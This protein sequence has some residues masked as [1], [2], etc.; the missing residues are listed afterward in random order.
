MIPS[1]YHQ[2]AP[3]H[4]ASADH[5]PRPFVI[6][7]H[8][9]AVHNNNYRTALWTGKHLQLTVMSIPPGEDIGLEVHP[10]VDQFLRIEAGRGLVQMGSYRDHLTFYQ[11]VF[12][13]S[14]IFIP[15]GTWH[16]VTNTGPM[17][18][19]LYSIY[20]PPNHR[21]SVVHETKQ[22]AEQEEP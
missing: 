12:D 1:G 6:D 21:H 18:L 20:A 3:A 8:K 5:G 11:P 17:P 15:A 22:I 7:I 13:D 10:L 2:S 16:N 19:K 9:A 14:A 4:P